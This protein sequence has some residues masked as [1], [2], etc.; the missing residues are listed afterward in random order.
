MPLFSISR[1]RFVDMDRE[2]WFSGT[3]HLRPTYYA[4][5][6]AGQPGVP[7]ACASARLATDQLTLV[8]P[9]AAD[10]PQLAPAASM[11]ERLMATEPH[12]ESQNGCSAA[13][14]DSRTFP[15]ASEPMAASLT[16]EA[17]SAL[18]RLEAACV[19]ASAAYAAGCDGMHCDCGRGSAAGMLL[20]RPSNASTLS[21]VR[22]DGEALE[23]LLPSRR[24]RRGRRRRRR[25]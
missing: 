19:S 22:N 10:S 1:W 2:F 5:P 25:V 3:Y 24:R 4:V 6:G 15:S 17:A 9:L 11:V 13:A 14:A 12:S 21:V 7:T 8:P 23:A 20:R 16:T 18:G